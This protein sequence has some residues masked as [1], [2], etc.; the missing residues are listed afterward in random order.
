MDGWIHWTGRVFDSE[1][2]A[3]VIFV[4]AAVR[5]RELARQKREMLQRFMK[6]EQARRLAECQRAHEIQKA[7]DQR[8]A[9]IAREKAM[10]DEL[11]KAKK[12]RD[13]N[14][15]QLVRQQVSRTRTRTRTYS[16]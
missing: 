16:Y 12:T 4:C 1:R 6:E 2:T 3:P 15:R 14:T 10:K 8:I 5:A 13:D 9:E 11:F 7:E